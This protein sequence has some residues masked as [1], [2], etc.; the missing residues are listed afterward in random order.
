MPPL[1]PLLPL[2]T[3]LVTHP[4]PLSPSPRPTRVAGRSGGKGEARPETG[5]GAGA[6]ARG[7]AGRG[8]PGGGGAGRGRERGGSQPRRDPPP[9]SCA[10]VDA[11][12]LE[13]PAPSRR[14][15]R[16]PRAPRPRTSPAPP[17][18]SP[19]PR[20]G[21]SFAAPARASPRQRGRRG[22]RTDPCPRPWAERQSRRTLAGGAGDGSQDATL[23]A[24]RTPRAL[25]SPPLGRS[26]VRGS[27]GGVTVPPGV[28]GRPQWGTC[29][30]TAAR[31]PVEH[32]GGALET[33]GEGRSRYPPVTG[34][35]ADPCPDLPSH[36][37]PGRP[38]PGC[39]PPTPVTTS[40]PIGPQ[41]G[42]RRRK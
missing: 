15:A 19:A 11:P 9:Q 39:G 38:Q 14:G 24:P 41:P 13:P 28:W 30:K 17:L 40:P 6:G 37:T 27:R 7:E 5:G 42:C 10:P 26:Q 4:L 34:P 29:P 8:R 12:R 23:E 33:G 25:P 22:N 35:V 3:P 2:P 32:P 21:P 20:L 31:E 36:R 16:R 1:L 18:P